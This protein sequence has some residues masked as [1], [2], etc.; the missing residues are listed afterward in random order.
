MAPSTP[1]GWSPSVCSRPPYALLSRGRVDARLEYG[2]TL[3]RPQQH[4]LIS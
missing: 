2:I 3:E 4:P 1:D